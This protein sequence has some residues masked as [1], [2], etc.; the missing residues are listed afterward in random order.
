MPDP[1]RLREEAEA[2]SGFGTAEQVDPV[3][4]AAGL[5]V[6][7]TVRVEPSAS[8][9]PFETVIRGFSSVGTYHGQPV[10]SMSDVTGPSPSEGWAVLNADDS[11]EVLDDAE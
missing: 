6:G 1:D 2:A 4:W 10:V 11:V 5:S 3:E 9:D 8:I 7:D